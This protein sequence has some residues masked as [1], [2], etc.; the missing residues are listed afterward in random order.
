MKSMLRLQRK[1]LRHVLNHRVHELIH[2][3]DPQLAHQALSKALTDQYKKSLFATANHLLGFKDVNKRTHGNI[4]K[5]LQ[6][7]TKRKLICVPRGCLKSTIACVAY[8]I[9]LLI[10]NPNLRILIDSE[11]YT[12]S[13]TFLREIK[14]HLESPQLTELF[15]KFRSEPWSEGEIIIKQRTKNL[16][17]GSIVCSGIGTTKVGMHYDIIIM[18][19]LNSD[20]NSATP[21][22]CEK[23]I[24]HYKGNISILEP[25]G[26]MVLIGTRWSEQD[27]ISHVLRNELGIE[28]IPKTG[29]YQISGLIS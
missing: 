24:S 16:K 1:E 29:Q 11:L 7:E 10:N 20:N 8:P 14:A 28:G 17:E 23:V 18:D 15:G 6:S 19:D 9:W 27:C 5:A 26:T 25:N 21:E 22:G 12:N 2:N 3:L 13:K 4:I